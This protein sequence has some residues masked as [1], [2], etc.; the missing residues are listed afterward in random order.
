M[1]K[2]IVV[3]LLG[4]I[5]IGLYSQAYTSKALIKSKTTFEGDSKERLITITEKEISITNFLASGKPYSMLIDKTEKKE[6]D[7]NE[8][9]TY[10]Y[11][12]AKEP[13]L[14][15]Q[16]EKLIIIRSEFKVW[17]GRFLSEIEV[18]NYEFVLR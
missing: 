17:M 16:Y 10:Y 2:L 1:K 12:T 18:V 15:G 7:F 5:C 8:N 11:C 13:N 9:C 6:F 14:S 4:C 3:I